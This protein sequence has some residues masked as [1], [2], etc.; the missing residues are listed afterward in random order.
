MVSSTVGFF[1]GRNFFVAD[2]TLLV[3]FL[4]TDETLLVTDERLFFNLSI[5]PSISV[6][7]L[8]YFSVCCHITMNSHIVYSIK[9]YNLCVLKRFRNKRN[10]FMY[11]ITFGHVLMIKLYRH[12]YANLLKNKPRCLLR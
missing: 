3:T 10:A 1:P 2:A 12:I 6:C 7:V 11:Y 5:K 9:L 4:V 8:I